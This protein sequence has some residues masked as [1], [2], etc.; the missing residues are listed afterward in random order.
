MGK[1]QRGSNLLRLNGS[2]FSL[3]HQGIEK[4]F[5]NIIIYSIIIILSIKNRASLAG[6]P[7]IYVL[8]DLKSIRR[9]QPILS[10][11]NHRNIPARDCRT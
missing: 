7:G 2:Q 8:I 11:G 4:I 3:L 5:P 10:A 6:N 1:I 9:F